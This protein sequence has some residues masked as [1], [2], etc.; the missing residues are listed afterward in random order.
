MDFETDYDLATQQIGLLNGID[1]VSGHEHGPTDFINNDLGPFGEIQYPDCILDR[2]NN[3]PAK[4]NGDVPQP[5]QFEIIKQRNGN[6]YMKFK[7]PKK[8]VKTKLIDQQPQQCPV[9]PC[10]AVFTSKLKLRKHVQEHAFKKQHRCDVC[11][12]EFNVLENLMLHRSLHAGDGRCPQCGKVF[13]RLASL[14][15]HIKTH[16]KSKLTKWDTSSTTTANNFFSSVLPFTD[17]YFTCT[18]GCDEMFPLEW[19]LKQH[20]NQFHPTENSKGQQEREE[21]AK[22]RKL[23]RRNLLSCQYCEKQFTKNCLLIRHERIHNG[24][25]PFSCDR[26]DR[27]FAQKN[28]LIIHQRRHSDQRM[29]QCTQCPQTFVQKGNLSSHIAKCHTYKEGEPSFPCNQCSCTFKKIGTLNAHISKFHAA[30]SVLIDDDLGFKLDDVMK[31]LNDLHRSGSLENELISKDLFFN[32]PLPVMP[33]TT[34]DEVDGN[35]QSDFA[36]TAKATQSSLKL[37]VH[38]NN[39]MVTHRSVMQRVYG[40]VRCYVCLYCPKEFRRPYDLV[41]HIRIHTKEK[42]RKKNPLYCVMTT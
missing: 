41:R 33:P 4:V 37:A 17:E 40:N 8:N 42:V 9:A 14:E 16:F 3:Y 10:R 38:T 23:K 34:S 28:T 30:Q 20:I 21:L 13:R 18:Q 7:K 26:C 36:D 39:G 1:I 15:G 5:H 11:L 25:K 29:F 22:Q 19:M 2:T 6:R 12:E 27:N 31:E 35:K 32:L 24:Q